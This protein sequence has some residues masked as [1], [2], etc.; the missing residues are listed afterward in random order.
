[1]S[2]ETKY[3]PVVI[4]HNWAKSRFEYFNASLNEWRE[5]RNWNTRERLFNEY[6]A[7][8]KD[9]ERSA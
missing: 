3:R 6:V 8:A 1:M 5:V 4:A 2:A 7:K 9:A